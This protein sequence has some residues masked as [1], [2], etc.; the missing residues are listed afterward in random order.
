MRKTRKSTCIFIKLYAVIFI[1][2]YGFLHQFKNV[3][4]GLKISLK[5]IL[6]LGISNSI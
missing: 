2:I 6:L 4:L 1:F 3:N 5:E